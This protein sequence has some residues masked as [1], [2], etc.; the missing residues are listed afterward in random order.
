MEEYQTFQCSY[1]DLSLMMLIALD[2]I[3]DFYNFHQAQH[4]ALVIDQEEFEW[5]YAPYHQVIIRI[6]VTIKMKAAHFSF[7]HQ[8]SHDL[9]NI[10]TKRV[11]AQVDQHLRLVAKFFGYH[12]RGTPIGN[13]RGIKSWLKEFVFKQKP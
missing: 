3:Q 9:F 7:I 2:L 11:V 5:I 12:V 13:I 1:Q 10:G 6:A 8:E 4:F